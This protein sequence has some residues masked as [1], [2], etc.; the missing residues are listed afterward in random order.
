[1]SRHVVFATAEIAPLARVGGLAEAASGLVRALQRTD[2]TVT[3]VLPDY[4]DIELDEVSSWALDLP[5]W[6][7]PARARRGSAGG[8]DDV[9][10]IDRPGLARPHPYVEPSTGEGWPDND[11]RFMCFSA[12]VADVARTLDPDVLHL[13][14]WHTSAALGFLPTPPPTVLTIHTLGYQ[15]ICDSSWLT[16]LPFESWRFAWFDGCNPLLG[17]IRSA[18]RIIAVSPN[19]A[20]EIVEPVGGMGLHE[21]LARRGD[22]LVGIRNGID[23]GS[24]NPRTDPHIPINYGLEEIEG[25]KQAARLALSEEFG[26]NIS[27]DVL[28]GVVSRLVDQKGVD[29]IAGLAPYLA[30]MKARMVLLGSGQ[31]N[32]VELVERAASDSKGRIAAVT[33]RYDEPL[34]HR[35][36]AGSDLLIMPSRCEPCGLAQMQAM[37]YGTPA[38]ATRVGGLVDTVIDVDRHRSTGTGFLT[39]TND[40]PGLVDATHR[41]IRSTRLASRRRLVQ[42]RAM[43]IDWS[44]DGPADQHIEVYEAAIARRAPVDRTSAT[45]ASVE[46]NVLADGDDST[47]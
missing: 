14:D 42:R 26:W 34:A 45:F 18:D 36:F 1:M 39:E 35:I 5:E 47:L 25:G 13:N 24:W 11:W 27:G 17:A 16:R 43:E 41:A 12:G 21:E 46:T 30:G 6:C 9:I 32:L 31:A 33:D 8:F 20:K 2:V 10:L 19:Y 44:W 38:V 23:V 7:R 40:L 3:V 29:L 28:L 22:A 15:G 4:G 37:A